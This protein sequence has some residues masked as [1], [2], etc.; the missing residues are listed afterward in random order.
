[1]PSDTDVMVY[2]GVPF[3]LSEASDMAGISILQP[4]APHC[5]KLLAPSPE[6][7]IETPCAPWLPCSKVPPSMSEGWQTLVNLV[8]KPLNSVCISGCSYS[9]RCTP[10]SPWVWIFN[11]ETLTGI[12]TRSSGR[13]PGVDLLVPLPLPRF[14]PRPRPLPR[15]PRP[16]FSSPSGSDWLWVRARIYSNALTVSEGLQDLPFFPSSFPVGPAACRFIVC[17]GGLG[18]TSLEW[19]LGGWTSVRLQ[20]FALHADLVGECS[21]PTSC[22]W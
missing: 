6:L 13:L 15:Q 11:P 4:T 18:W 20:P 5:T 10:C 2:V 16:V 9:V 14:E 22:C 19:Q 17:E 21:R 1:M 8:S 7:N 12:P 3:G